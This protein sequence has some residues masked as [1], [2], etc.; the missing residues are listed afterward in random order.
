[1]HLLPFLPESTWL[2]WFEGGPFDLAAH[3]RARTTTPKSQ[4]TAAD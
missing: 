4:C 2:P 3:H 1:V